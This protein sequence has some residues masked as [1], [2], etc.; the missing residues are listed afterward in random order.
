MSEQTAKGRGMFNGTPQ[1][2][3]FCRMH[4][5]VPTNRLEPSTRP[6]PWPTGTPLDLPESFAFDG[7]SRSS[8]ALFT[9]TDTSALLVLHDGQVRHERYALTGGPEV[10]WLSMSVAKSFIS[11]L[12]GI[13][14]GEGHFNS[15]DEPI[16][17]Y[18]PVEPG[19]A[20]DGVT[21]KQV[22]HMSSGAR[23]NEDYGD[24]QSDITRL[25]A[26]SKGK[27]GSN[28]DQFI[29]SMVRESEP[30]VIC[31]YN[32]A[33]TQV[34]GALIKHT[35][36]ESITDYMQQRLCEPLGFASPGYWMVD[37]TGMEHAFGGLNLA[38]RDFARIGE[39]FR[40]GGRWHGTQIVPE[41]WVRDS[42]SVDDPI[43]EPGNPVVG[44]HSFDLGYGYQWWIPSGDRGEFMGIGVYNQFVYVDPTAKVTI[45]KLSANPRYGLSEDESDSRIMESIAFFRA[46][47]AQY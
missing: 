20:Y 10:P 17:R 37:A 12:V 23:W 30:D 38:A 27:D 5:L 4:D 32:S 35:T 1:Y 19:S 44:G 25:V 41:Q 14:L 7:Q 3:N 2:D 26:A 21:I 39:L 11:T 36:G 24:R 16:S 22:L 15:I 47:A 28:L 18:V 42:T 34:L 45:V 8:E 13:A 46:I 40:N 9:E 43:R 33:E 6:R 31:R 29:A